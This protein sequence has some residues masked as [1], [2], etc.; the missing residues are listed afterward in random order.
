VDACPYESLGVEPIINAIGTFTRLGGSLMPAEVVEAMRR[1]S[2]RFVCMEELQHAAGRAIAGMTGAESAYVTSGAQAG[3][4]LSVAAC[5]TGL[6]AARMDRLPD[7]SGLRREVVMDRR[8]RNHYD[9]AVE[10]AGGVIV[11]AED[12][13]EAIN[14]RTVAVLHLP[15]DEDRFPLAEVVRV[16]H[17][18][19][20]PVIVDAAGRCDEPGNLTRFTAAG[21]DLVC[22]SGGKYIRGPQASGFVCGRRALISAIAWQ[23]LDMD[24]TPRVWTAPRELLDPADLAHVPRQ[25]IG[26]GYKAGKE[27]IVGLVAALR[28]YFLRDHA[29]EK[30]AC[31]AKLLTICR[32]L[33][34]V[35]HVT[36]ELIEP[37]PVQG[38]F[39]RARV[40][41]EGMD[42][43]DFIWALKTG[44]PSIHPGERELER[45]AVIIHPFG[46]QDGDEREI[47]RRVKE[48]ASG[49]RGAAR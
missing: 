1:A 43:Y 8:H 22:W 19:G 27:E 37:D 24:I 41:I 16:A 39:A 5:I 18:H 7:A 4:V 2:L 34:A 13:A 29:A 38:G 47:V 31:R 10:A 28:L 30:A 26:R 3:L 32:D 9:H 12:V 40:R 6:D 35:P 36:A 42:G 11:E 23:H 48:V 21:A 20:V 15:W 44:K 49:D 17:G 25:G 14:G 45:G 33:Q 46:L